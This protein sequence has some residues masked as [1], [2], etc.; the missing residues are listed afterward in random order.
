MNNR[1]NVSD[2]IRDRI[3]RVLHSDN[4]GAFA[5]D[6]DTLRSRLSREFDDVLNDAEIQTGVGRHQII[7]RSIGAVVESED[8]N[9]S[10]ETRMERKIRTTASNRSGQRTLDSVRADTIEE[11]RLHLIL[12][13]ESGSSQAAHYI[14]LGDDTFDRVYLRLEQQERA[15]HREIGPDGQT[16]IGDGGGDLPPPPPE[17]PDDDQGGPGET[18]GGSFVKKNLP[19]LVGAVF[20]LAAVVE[21]LGWLNIGP[22]IVG[23]TSTP[24]PVPTFA[25][26]VA[27]TAR[28]VPPAPSAPQASAPAP[29]P[30]N[31]P[32]ATPTRT[33]RPTARSVA[34]AHARPVAPAPHMPAPSGALTI[35][36]A[37]VNAP[38]G[39]PRFCT[40]GCSE[41]IYMSGLTETLFNSKANRD[42]TVTTEPML[43]LDFTLDPSLEF[44]TFN[45]R[46][47]VQ[48]HHGWGEMTARDV[49]YSFN[50][51]N[52]VTNPVSIHGQAGDF[53]PL[54]ASI[55]AVDDYTVQ[56]NYRNYD[57]R[58]VLHR[59]SRFWQ[60][61]AIVSRD[62]Y[63]QYGVEGTQD[64][65]V[66]VGAFMAEDAN[67]TE[68]WQQNLGIELVANP[69][70]YATED[71]N[72]PF[73]ERVRWLE[74]PE[75]ASRRAMLEA[76]DAQIAQ[77][78]T[79]DFPILAEQG[80]EF[81]KKGLF[82]TIRNVSFVGNYWD[83]HSGLTGEFLE[84]ERDTSLPWVGNPFEMGDFDENTPSMQR[85]RMVRNALAW[86]IQR[87]DLVENLLG[88]LGFVNH[89][90]YLSS[91]NPNY[92]EDWSWGTDFDGARELMWNAGYDGFEMDL[93]V[94]TGEL[95]AE[96]GEA[97]GADWEDHLGLRVN[98]IKTAYSTYRPGLVART[99]KT[100]GVNICGDEN[101][102]NFPYDWAH[103]F[104]VS[105]FSAGGYGVGQE[106]PYATEIYSTMAGEPDKAER[107]QMAAR[108]Y[109]ENR[110][111][112]NCVG[113]FEEPLWPVYDP[114][115]I[116]QWDM[117]PMANGNLG[118]INNVRTIKL[119]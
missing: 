117:R 17:P 107:E 112:A 39:L 82:N 33:P 31:T 9:S 48:F 99:N 49:A 103:G 8:L 116:T 102:S 118:T 79:K 44:G 60:T 69:D 106:L 86:S 7:T 35:A 115:E 87:E 110:R 93:W 51:A 56:L 50:D 90:P 89:Q 70:Y 28:P 65:Y 94:G 67:Y 24:T 10:V 119:R 46:Q 74:V 88:G 114:Y 72:G 11:N 113:L 97:V 34:P 61:A 26:Q 77:I 19:I 68:S 30:T 101:K 6:A 84:R 58:G 43:A 66:G 73:V 4:P 5:T 18:G 92:R 105:S 108:F 83:S 14:S 25:P 57:S 41:T 55:E 54:I 98:L 40:A 36:V 71:G 37:G 45:L 96:I 23:P 15:V 81:Q 53:A 80:F 1:T 78:A 76:N 75:G 3:R 42:G 27:P 111:W 47:G 100:P 21:I 104:V 13:V 2:M 16:Y 20:V 52:S 85:S 109:S 63:D 38:N 22:G 29:T 59:F 64:V 32:T 62:V 91:N 95:G 12:L